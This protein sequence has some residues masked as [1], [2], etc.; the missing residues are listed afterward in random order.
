[1]TLGPL[2]LIVVSFPS[3]RLTDG[4]L[5][6]L[7]GLAGVP[8]I[9]VADV[10]VVRIDAGGG[11]CAVELVDLP[12]LGGD[13]SE[14]ARL[15]TGLITAIDVEEVGGLVDRHNDAVAVLVENLW[16]N[17]LTAEVTSNDGAVLA[18]FHKPAVLEVRATTPPATARK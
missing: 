10:L 5:A 13:P 3:A 18:L 16:V 12:G 17:D 9:R 7:G 15:A 8:G 4:V 2:H 11:A 1:M 6:T 14:L